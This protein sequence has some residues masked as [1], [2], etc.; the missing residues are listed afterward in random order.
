[1]STAE[2][3]QKSKF[4]RDKA[5]CVFINPPS[6]LVRPYRPA[7]RTPPFHGGNRG[8]NPR[9]V[10]IFPSPSVFPQ[11]TYS[12]LRAF[13]PRRF[14]FQPTWGGSPTCRSGESP[15]PRW[16]GEGLAR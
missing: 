16:F 14:Q 2:R 10:A 15:T 9:R 7:V 1:T 11:S 12:N 6:P 4:S 5:G 8:S 13:A 3:L